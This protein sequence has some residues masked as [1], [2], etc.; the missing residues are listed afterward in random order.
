MRYTLVAAL[1]SVAL[2]AGCGDDTESDSKSSADGAAAQDP[3]PPLPKESLAEFAKKLETVSKADCQGAASLLLHTTGRK[4][5]TKPGAPPVARECK[6]LD[7]YKGLYEGFKVKKTYDF[8]PA[9][10][11]QGTGKEAPGKRLVT[12]IV[13]QDRDGHYKAGWGGVYDPQDREPLDTSDFAGA[14][15]KWVAATSKGECDTTFRYFLGDARVIL[16]R[17]N[18][19]VDFCNDVSAS[20]KQDDSTFADIAGDQGKHK[21][22]ELGKTF[23]IAFYGLPLSSGR[24]NVLILTTKSEDIDPKLQKGH[25]K[26]VGVTDY[27]TVVNPND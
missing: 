13:V 11:V 19:Q 4:R 21:P 3:K 18:D 8:G 20:Y 1:A 15:E 12:A 6:S 9:G 7:Q 17:K 23:D 24:Y 2:L 27:P 10:V 22:V 16:A 5:G 14:A 25:D 26:Y